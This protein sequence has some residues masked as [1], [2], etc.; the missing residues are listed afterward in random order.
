MGF[1]FIPLSQGGQKGILSLQ[2]KEERVYN[3]T[4]VV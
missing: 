2:G 4:I 3:E 1:L